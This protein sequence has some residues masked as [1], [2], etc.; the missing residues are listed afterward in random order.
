MNF[1]KASYI[2]DALTDICNY[3]QS[4]KILNNAVNK[5]LLLALKNEQRFREAK[6]ITFPIHLL[7]FGII[8]ET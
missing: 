2:L 5:E 6:I 3:I 7:H 1:L 4:F 8:I